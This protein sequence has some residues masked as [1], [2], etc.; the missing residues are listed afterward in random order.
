MKSKAKSLYLTFAA[1]ARARL[2]FISMANSRIGPRWST[3]ELFLALS[4]LSIA[5]TVLAEDSSLRADYR[6]RPPEMVIDEKTGR[7]SGPLIDILDE[8]ARKIGHRIKWRKAPFQRSYRE[9]QLGSVDVVPRVILT[10]ERKAFVAYLGPIGYQRKD[11]VFL[12]RKGQESLINTYDD[13]RKINV[14]TKRDTAYFKQFNEDKSIT[15]IL[16]LDDKNMARMFAADRFDTMII[17]DIRAI[18]TVLKNIG[19][20]NYSYANY[21]YVQKIGNYYG[22][23]KESPRIE[24]YPKLN[25]ALLGLVQSGRVKEIYKHHGIAPPSD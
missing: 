25:Q 24:L 6:Q 15:K 16:S 19:F 1:Q 22:M 21:R 4:L 13:L 18:E 11:I 17:L 23:S 12:V 3:L 7:F 5:G 2:R 20:N 8:A 10:E 9:L 14:G